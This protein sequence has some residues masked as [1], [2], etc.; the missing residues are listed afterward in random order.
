MGFGQVVHL[1][2]IDA[3]I[4]EFPRLVIEGDEFP[5]AGTNG[6][7]PLVLEEKSAFRAAVVELVNEVRSRQ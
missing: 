3:E 7:V 4:V 6:A 2:A 5:F 1:S